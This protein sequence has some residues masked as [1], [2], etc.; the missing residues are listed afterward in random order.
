MAAE[1]GPSAPA[2]GIAAGKAAGAATEYLIDHPN[3]LLQAFAC[4]ENGVCVDSPAGPGNMD[5]QGS[6][7]RQ[8]MENSFAQTNDQNDAAAAQAAQQAPDAQAALSS[9]SDSGIL[10]FLGALSAGL[11]SAAPLQQSQH[12]QTSPLLPASGHIP[13][14]WVE[15]T[16]PS[17]HTSIG[18]MINGALYHPEG[19]QCK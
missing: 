2:I 9:Q 12:P 17:Q 16:C 7:A 19:P 3:T 10:D 14:G 11:N 6:G 8:D 4:D 13:A 5:L 15:C 1:T 18:R